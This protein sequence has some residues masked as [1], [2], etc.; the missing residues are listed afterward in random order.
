[1]DQEI[2]KIDVTRERRSNNTIQSSISLVF[3]DTR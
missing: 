2:S 1:M 3:M